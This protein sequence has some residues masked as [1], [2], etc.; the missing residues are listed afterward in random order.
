M[1]PRSCA[2]S[3]SP[4]RPTGSTRC[5]PIRGGRASPSS[6][7]AP[8]IRPIGSTTRS[9]ATPTAT[10]SRSSGS[11]SR[12]CDRQRGSERLAA[13]DAPPHQAVRRPGGRGR[14]AARDPPGRGARPDRAQRLGQDDDGEPPVRSLPGRRGRDPALRRA[15]R[16]AAAARDHR[17][18]RR[19]DLPD[20]EA[21]RQHDRARERRASGAD[22]ARPGR[23]SPI[24]R[25]PRARATP[26]RAGDARRS[27]PRGGPGAVGRAE[28][29]T[30]DRARPDGAPDPAVPDGRALCRRP[31]DDQG[32]DHG[33]HPPDEPGGGRD[34]PDRVPR[35]GDPAPPVPA[36]LG[37]ARG[38]AHR[39]G[40]VR[41]SRQPHRGA[42]SLPGALDGAARARRDRRR[43][44]RRHRHSERSEPRRR[45]G[46][47]DWHHRP[48]RRRQIHLAQDDLRISSPAGGPHRLRRARR[49]APGAP[50]LEAA[51]DRLRTAGRERVSAADGRR[52]PPDRRLGLP[53][54]SRPRERDARARLHGVPASLR[55]APAP[56]HR[57]LGRRGEDALGRQGAGDR[58]EPAPGRRALGRARAAYRRAGVRAA[59]RG[60]GRRS[61]D[62]PGR[63][64]H[65]EGR[66]GLRLP[67]YARDGQGPP[68][69]PAA[70]LRR[71]AARDHPRRAARSL[72][73]PRRARR[74]GWCLVAYAALAWVPWSASEYHTHVLVTCFYY[75]I[76]AIG[77]NLLAGYTGQFSLA[78]H[79]FAGVGAYT[80]ALLVRYAHVPILAGIGAGAVVAAAMGYGLGTLC[81]R[82]RAI[83]LALATW[84]FAES[85]RLLITVEYE[86]TRGDLGL[87]A[88][89]LFRTPRPTPY[90]YLFLALALV[91][92]LVARELIDSRIGS[93]MRAI[94]DDEEAASVMGV[95]T[96]KWKRFVFALSAVFA[97]VAGGFQGHY[98]GL[99]SPTPMK[100]N[101][102]AMIVVMVI[103][104]GLRTF[105]GPI[106]GAV[107][108]EVLSEALRPWGEVRMVL[109]ALLVIA[110]ARGYPSGLVGICRAA[111]ERV[112]ARVP[113]LAPV[114]RPERQSD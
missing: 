110:I 12:W 51:R 17:A 29:A 92:I 8:T 63:P 60:A 56:R 37:D 72:I 111:G 57:A 65:H 108:I 61:D 2:A 103:V 81:L 95:D 109:F 75:V 9:C 59:S 69:G 74:L 15:D 4:S 89:F 22:R 70:G 113:A 10:S 102:M 100:F 18:R 19:A 39:R 24:E 96:F 35:D 84:A 48:Q 7:S 40:I 90:Y 30:A 58:A 106:L 93:Y 99:L 62:S 68:R 50:R 3:R 6:R 14:S 42:R 31:P 73:L 52:E 45:Q 77:W 87:A 98:V 23:S 107:F 112:A 80:S 79:T 94:R 26:A 41:G 49:R 27:S 5:A 71:P 46:N 83:Y 1:R 36:R 82:M 101:E 54:R 114:L 105:A 78:H 85:L 16:P 38:Q 86:I 67:L 44:R 25:D 28:H 47:G 21:L 97:A 64:E 91:A 66:R 20:A 76:L 13:R 53:A 34:V 55:Q 104:G 88:P 43:L 11:G 32:H 33:D